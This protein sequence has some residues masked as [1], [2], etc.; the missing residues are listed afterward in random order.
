MNEMVQ[1]PRKLLISA[2]ATASTANEPLLINR[3]TLYKS[4]EQELKIKDTD[5]YDKKMIHSNDMPKGY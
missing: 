1:N 3:E 4:C 5:N 2:A